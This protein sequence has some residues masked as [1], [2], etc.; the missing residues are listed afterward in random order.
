MTNAALNVPDGTSG[1]DFFQNRLDWSLYAVDYQR[2]RGTLT[3]ARLTGITDG[4][5]ADTGA[6]VTLI[7]QAESGAAI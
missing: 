5:G 4:I 2:E 7:G 3:P 1:K 6:L